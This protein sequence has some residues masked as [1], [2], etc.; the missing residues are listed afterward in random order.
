MRRWI[1]IAVVV[2][3]AIILAI[4]LLIWLLPL[5]LLIMLAILLA[6]CLLLLPIQIAVQT[7]QHGLEA[8][9]W[10]QLKLPF[11]K[12][13]KAINITDKVRQA[14][15]TALKQWRK[16]RRKKGDAT[17]AAPPPERPQPKRRLL[18][19]RLPKGQPPPFRPV[20]HA[21]RLPMRYFARHIQFTQWRLRAEVGGFDA[22]QSA[23]LAGA[24]WSV[25]GTALGVVSTVIRLDPSVP[26]IAIVPN[27][28]DPTWRLQTDCI[29]RF[30]LGHAIVA[31]V[32]ALGRLLRENELVRWWQ[33]SRRRKG[34]EGSGRKSDSGPDEDGHGKHQGH[35]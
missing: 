24:L 33:E 15:Q 34:V 27:F 12:F 20:M 6:L 28:T 14:L 4:A 25:V 19:A 9:V 35:D 2:A 13:S 29:L 16:R 30:R 18:T 10:V 23:L 3:V 32:W 8:T 7:R 31:G 5:W 22:M 1:L 26:K 17:N 11:L 21:V